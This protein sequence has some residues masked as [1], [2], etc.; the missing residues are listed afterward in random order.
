MFWLVVFISSF[1]SIVLLFILLITDWLH[2]EPRS[3]LSSLRLWG[4]MKEK[5][6]WDG[7]ADS[8]LLTQF[9]IR[10]GSVALAIAQG[11]VLLFILL[12]MYW[13]HGEPRSKLA[14]L[15]L[16]GGMKEKTR[17]DGFADSTRYAAIPLRASPRKTRMR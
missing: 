17:W 8:K 2:G 6:R 5:N 9:L 16:W 3:R 11:I 14:S 4:G 13:L 1:V 12:I 15:R 7:F 10:A